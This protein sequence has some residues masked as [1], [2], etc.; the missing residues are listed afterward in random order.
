MLVRTVLFSF[1]GITLLWG[2]Q[3]KVEPRWHTIP[4]ENLYAIDL[5][6]KLIVSNDMHE[7]ASLQYYDLANDFYVIGMEEPKDNIKAV[8]SEVKMDDYYKMVEDTITSGAVYKRFIQG[9]KSKHDGISMKA[10]DYE[11]Q[12]DLRGKEYHLLY[13]IAIFESKKYFY[14]IVMYMP[15]SDSCKIFPKLDTI[16]QSFKVLNEEG[17]KT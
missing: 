8:N 4:I 10:S 9:Q 7:S 14:Q 3:K 5:P 16:I 15:Y 17:S 2:C 11:I 1:C 13:R 12:K 6:S